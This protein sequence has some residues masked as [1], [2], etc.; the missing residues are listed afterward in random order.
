MDHSRCSQYLH[1]S[2]PTNV[3]L[4]DGC[5]VPVSRSLG[6]VPFKGT[7]A[8]LSSEIP[9]LTLGQQNHT[10]FALTERSV[11]IP[12]ALSLHPTI[13]NNSINLFFLDFCR[14]CVFLTLENAWNFPKNSAVMQATSLGVSGQDLFSSPGQHPQEPYPFLPPITV[15]FG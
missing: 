1:G 9:P 13:G 12:S 15:S 7:R 2:R 3:L 8:W 10:I 14:L 6:W 11:V 4:R 5:P